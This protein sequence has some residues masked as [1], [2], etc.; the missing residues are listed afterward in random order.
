S[1]KSSGIIV[2]AATGNYGLDNDQFF[3]YPASY[4]L[5]NIVSVA[6]TTNRDGLAFFSCFGRR[7]VDIA[8]PGNDIIS[9]WFSSDTAY[10]S[11]SGTSLAAPHV[12]GVLAQL[13]A[14]VSSESMTETIYRMYANV[15]PLPG[16]KY[17]TLSGGRIN[18]YRALNST[19]ANPPGD[20]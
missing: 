14:R 1:L 16:L 2:V 10:Q 12:A 4:D 8:A 15:D 7:T 5:D 20:H 17:K 3:T 19:L 13:R 18:L 9:T 11:L 6:A